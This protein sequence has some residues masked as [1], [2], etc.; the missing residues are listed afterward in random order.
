MVEELKS[1]FQANKPEIV[2]NIDRERA[3]REGIT[4]DQIGTALRIALSGFAPTKFRD[5]D[6]EYDITIRMKED[7]RNNINTLMNLNLTYRDMNMGG[8][9][10]QVPL[11]AVADI[12]YSNTYAGIKHKDENV[13]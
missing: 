10:R 6:D 13:W 2:V 11:S 3:N 4:T 9:I 1:D 7:Q 12:R 5:A 8:A